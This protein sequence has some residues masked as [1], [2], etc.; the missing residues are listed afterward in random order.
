MANADPKL[1]EVVK[2]SKGKNAD[3]LFRIGEAYTGYLT[4]GNGSI[5]PTY[6]KVVNA[7]QSH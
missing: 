4:P 6:P 5:K 1:A 7:D 3:I 2:K